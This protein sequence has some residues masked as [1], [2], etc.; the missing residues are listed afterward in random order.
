MRLA[1]RTL[2]KFGLSENEIQVYMTLIKTGSTSPFRLSKATNIPRT[3]IYEI[4][5]SLSLKGLIELVKSDG[6]T[7][8]QTRIKA[9]DPSTLRSI[10]WQRR[11]E[12]T[13]LEADVVSILPQL[14]QDFH[15]E[16]PNADFQFYPGI[17]G[18][19]KVYESEV[20]EDVDL[21]IF[22]WDYQMQMDAFGREFVNEEVNR[23]TELMKLGKHREK[24]LFPLT[25]WSKHV[26][27]YQYGR[28]KQYIHDRELRYIDNALFTLKQRIS[29]RGNILR[30]V[31]IEDGENWGLV[32]HSPAIV[33]TFSSWFVFMWQMG[34]PVT[35]STMKRWGENEQLKVELRGK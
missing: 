30:I 21:P 17:E 27:T 19:K 16:E 7:K 35:D 3:S 11:K 14:K 22:V 24:E 5:T 32:I 20:T 15:K 28:D 8:Q 12:L 18:A 33:K 1:E 10:L 31:C 26:V 2:A 13:T 23:G 25:E 4:I 29:V 6:F 34:T 9:H